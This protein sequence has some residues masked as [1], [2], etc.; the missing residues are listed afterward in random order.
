MRNSTLGREIFGIYL[1]LKHLRYINEGRD[2]IIFT[3]RKLLTYATG[4][5]SDKYD[6]R[7]VAHLHYI[8][9]VT[10]DNRH[11]DGMKNKVAGALPKP[12]LSALQLSD[13]T[14]LSAMANGQQRDGR[15][16]DESSSGLLFVD[17]AITTGVNTIICGV[18][19]SSQ[20][21][22]VPVSM[23]RAMLQLFYDISHPGIPTP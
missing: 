18:L 1:V 17:I 20:Q 13:R 12:S 21:P 8:S 16:D 5:H 2:F 15:P 23:R 6:T 22:L 14:S 11:I 7:E 10:T 19:T 9:K 3:D 4:S